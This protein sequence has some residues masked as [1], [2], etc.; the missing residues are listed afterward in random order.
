LNGFVNK[1]YI[2]LFLP[3]HKTRGFQAE[4]A[5]LCAFSAKGLEEAHRIVGYYHFWGIHIGR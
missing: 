2:G 5:K 1:F 4:T 3:A